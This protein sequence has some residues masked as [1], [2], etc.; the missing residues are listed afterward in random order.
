MGIRRG[1]VGQDSKY[2]ISEGEI[3]AVKGRIQDAITHGLPEVGWGGDPH[4]RL[5]FEPRT[6]T[7]IVYDVAI[8]PP[9]R[10][11]TKPAEG[12]RDLDFR[13]LCRRLAEAQFTGQGVDT[14]IDRMER[15]N[16]EV[17]KQRAAKRYEVHLE[18]AERLQ[19]AMARDLDR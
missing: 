4:L 17:E 5:V 13:S 3:K 8:S 2:R 15:R 10:V 14:I 6:E 19:W 12:I 7:W 11:I 9:D 16:A 1:R 18:L